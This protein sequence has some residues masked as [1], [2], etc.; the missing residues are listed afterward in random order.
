MRRLSPPPQGIS[1]LVLFSK[2]W[3]LLF[4]GTPIDADKLQWE[5]CFHPDQQ[6][7]YFV[8]SGITSGFHLGLDPL[9]VSLKSVTQNMSSASLHPAVIDQYLLTEL[10]KGRVAGH[11]SMSPIPNLH[12]SH[13]GV[14]PKK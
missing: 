10:Q 11:L 5:L 6:K 12:V 1:L 4:R 8:I 2:S 7:V 14:I 9:A 13:F 3:S